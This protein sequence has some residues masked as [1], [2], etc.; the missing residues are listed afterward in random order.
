LVI[1]SSIKQF[2]LKKTRK[3]YQITFTLSN[4]E[5]FFTIML[6]WRS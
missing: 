1:K 4:L 5:V 2:L 3:L 6:L